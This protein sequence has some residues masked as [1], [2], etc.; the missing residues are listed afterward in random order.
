MPANCGPYRIMAQRI[1]THGPIETLKQRMTGISTTDLKSKRIGPKN[2]TTN[3]GDKRISLKNST[4]NYGDK[5][6][7]TTDLGS[8][9]I[10]LKHK[11]GVGQL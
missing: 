4:T 9:R 8:K 5:R 11:A 6:I 1:S 7:S 2:S 10:G 3:Y